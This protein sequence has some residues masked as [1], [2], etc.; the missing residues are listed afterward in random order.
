[1]YLKESSH[2]PYMNL[3]VLC[4]GSEGTKNVVIGAFRNISLQ[5]GSGYTS[6]RPNRAYFFVIVQCLV[7]ILNNVI[8]KCFTTLFYSKMLSFSTNN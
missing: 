5:K 2:I 8:Y 4:C 3:E 7:I 6:K 1:M